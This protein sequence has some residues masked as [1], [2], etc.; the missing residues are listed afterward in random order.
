MQPTLL[1]QMLIN[2]FNASIGRI[3]VEDAE[4]EYDSWPTFNH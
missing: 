2:P 4:P 3:T 1:S